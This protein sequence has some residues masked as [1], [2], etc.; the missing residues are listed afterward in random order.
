[1]KDIVLII[2]LSICLITDIKRR[3]IYNNVLLPALMLG[4]LFNVIEG[5]FQGFKESVLGMMAGLGILM[6]PFIS[7]GIGG[8]DVKLLAVIGAIKG[9]EF[10]F[11]SSMTMGVAGGLIAL[12]TLIYNKKLTKTFKSMIT[13]IYTMFITRFKIISFDYDNE[14]IMFPYGIAIAL[15]AISAFLVTG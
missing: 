2:T 7:G 9:Y 5:G 6:I 14:K 1:M 4:I 12:G 10:V 8:G 13:G 11:Y 15:G 3:K